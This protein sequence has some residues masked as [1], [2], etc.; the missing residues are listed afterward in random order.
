M[1]AVSEVMAIEV[2]GNAKG[3]RP[4]SME[5]CDSLSRGFIENT[6]I[7]AQAAVLKKAQAECKDMA[8]ERV[9]DFIVKTN[10]SYS[11]PFNSVTKLSVE[12]SAE[13]DCL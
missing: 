1:S 11:G 12:V 8:A 13:F 7:E 9:S 5:S 3:T 6:T 4:Y 10:C 2:K